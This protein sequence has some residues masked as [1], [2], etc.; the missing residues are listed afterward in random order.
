[1]DLDSI[2]PI[3]GER[4]WPRTDCSLDPPFIKVGPERP[5]KNMIKAPDESPKKLGKLIRHGMEMTCG[6]CKTKGHNERRCP[7]RATVQN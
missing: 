1:M 6:V 5:R 2:P 7:N 4:H 3:E